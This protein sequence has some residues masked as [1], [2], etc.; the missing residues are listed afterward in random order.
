MLLWDTPLSENTSKVAGDSTFKGNN[1]V[2]FWQKQMGVLN[3]PVSL[4]INLPA[5]TQEISSFPRP[6]LTSEG[7]ISYNTNLSRDLTTQVS[8]QKR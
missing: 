5:G 8:W 4:R 1:L 3:D 2:F 7:S 6:L